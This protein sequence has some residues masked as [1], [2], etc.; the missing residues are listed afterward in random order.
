[1]GRKTVRRKKRSVGNDVHRS[2]PRFSCLKKA[3]EKVTARGEEV[4]NANVRSGKGKCPLYHDMFK[5]YSECVKGK[6]Q[7]L[8]KNFRTR[9]KKG[10]QWEEKVVGRR[11]DE[12]WKTKRR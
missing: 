12:S 6:R 2:L 10:E 11:L 9:E 5:L 8:K 4:A 3:H 1:L 7:R